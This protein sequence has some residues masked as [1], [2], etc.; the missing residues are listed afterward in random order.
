MNNNEI[1]ALFD[2]WNNALKTGNPK[3]VA[4]LYANRRYLATDRFQQGPPQS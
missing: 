2:Q 3:E 1:L 4:A